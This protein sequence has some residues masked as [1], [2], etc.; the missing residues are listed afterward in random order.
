MREWVRSQVPDLRFGRGGGGQG[1]YL[2]QVTAVS[3]MVLPGT[4]SSN[5]MELLEFFP[6]EVAD[7]RRFF[8][9]GM[10]HPVNHIQVMP[11]T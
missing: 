8:W 2:V 10:G 1:F 4:A 5:G 6:A 7:P 9:V 3:K 11:K